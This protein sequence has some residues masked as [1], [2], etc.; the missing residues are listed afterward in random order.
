MGNSKTKLNKSNKYTITG[1]ELYIMLIKTKNL[2]D[3]KK[4][5][6]EYSP[7]F[8]YKDINDV[9]L[10]LL[11]NDKLKNEYEKIYIWFLRA[12]SLPIA[13]NVDICI[14]GITLNYAPEN[15]LLDMADDKWSHEKGIMCQF[16]KISIIRKLFD[17][18]KITLININKSGIDCYEYLHHTAYNII[19]QDDYFDVNIIDLF[20]KLDPNYIIDYL[21]LDKQ[22]IY[23]NFI[24][25]MYI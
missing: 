4:I 9:F 14:L 16:L 6:K 10:A 24:R 20:I 2:P 1:T 19:K 25:V 18:L 7:S 15:K 5:K 17:L 8:T 11:K 23:K 21:P 3:I 12:T 22:E 13:H